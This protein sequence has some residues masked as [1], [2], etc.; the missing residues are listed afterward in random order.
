MERI[1]DT[2]A[3]RSRVSTA[4]DTNGDGTVKQQRPVAIVGGRLVTP[5]GIREGTLRLAEGRI[6]GFGDPHA[7]DEVVEASGKLVAPGLVDLGVFAVDKPAF[8]FGGI[9]R[10]ALM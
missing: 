10:A 5:D 7:G 6:A 4:L 9:T 3:P 2:H 8:R 1:R